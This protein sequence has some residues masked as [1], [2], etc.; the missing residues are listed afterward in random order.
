MRRTKAFSPY[1]RHFRTIPRPASSSHNR[2][3]ERPTT[4][5]LETMREI[6]DLHTDVANLRRQLDFAN[7]QLRAMRI[8]V[9]RYENI[10]GMEEREAA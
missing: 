2:F 8:Q 3:M 10:L 4:E 9:N 5:Q 7:Q 1:L 6:D